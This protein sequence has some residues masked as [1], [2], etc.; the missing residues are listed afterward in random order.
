MSVND[1]KYDVISIMDSIGA[2]SGNKLVLTLPGGVAI[3]RLPNESDLK[4]TE[5]I[6]NLFNDSF[7]KNRKS[8]KQSSPQ[9]IGLIDVVY[10]SGPSTTKLPYMV[11]F[12]DQI[13]GISFGS[14]EEN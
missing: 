7:E 9:A 8:E 1:Y 5:S 13:V 10:N 2:V 6:L 3:G 4:N 11:F 12:I 14:L